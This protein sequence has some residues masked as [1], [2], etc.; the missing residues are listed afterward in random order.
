MSIYKR[1]GVYWYKFQWKGAM[2]RE[3]TKQGNDKV[4]R[5]MEAAHRTS[6]AKGEVGIRDKKPVPTLAEFCKKR[7]EPWGESTATR[8]TWRD[9]YRVGL[10]AIKGY[11]PLANLTLDAV[12]SEK[13][14]DFAS[15]RQAQG[16][17]V[18]S[19]NSSL[20]ILRRVLRVAVEWGELGTAPKVKLLSGERHRERVLTADEEAQYLVAASGLLADV[21]TVLVDTGLRP[22][23]CYRLL[24]DSMTWVNGRN[25]TLLVTH[26]KTKAAR[27]VLP[28]TPRVR[29]ILEIRWKRLRKTIGGLCI[30]CADQERAH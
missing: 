1:G 7:F 5:Q 10:L 16:L 14:A 2:V 23:E 20:R 22:E 25:G 12:G 3:S 19:V 26:G 30:A 4:G 8:K 21:A 11:A 15:Y 28:M 29:Q 18:S 24:W 27:R 9:F 17:Q 13:I 6:L